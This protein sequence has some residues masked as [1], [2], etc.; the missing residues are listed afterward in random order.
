MRTITL[1]VIQLFA[2]FGCLQGQTITLTF[3]ATF[4]GL[5]Q[6][7]DSITVANI[8]QGGD[9]ILYGND[10]IL[11]LNHAIG[12]EDAFPN[13]SGRMILYPPSPNPVLQ[14]ATIRLYLPRDE[15]VTLSIHDLQGRE[16]ATFMQWLPA[17]DH[18]FTLI[19]G[20]ETCY[21]LS[22]ETPGQQQVQKLV[23]LAGTGNEP[24]IA[25][26]GTRGGL[27]SMKVS[28]AGFPW[29]P[30]D[31]MRFVG[32]FANGTDTLDGQPTQS[33]QYTFQY[34]SGLCPSTVTDFN[35]NIYNT[36]QIG[37]QCWMKE[38]LKVRNYKNGTSITLVTDNAA[39]KDITSSARC[40]YNNDSATYAATYG[41]LY[42]WYA[43]DN[44]SGLCPTGWHVPNELEWQTMEMFLGMTQ[45][46]ANSIGWRGT[47]EG[48]KMKEAG[49]THW[50]SPNTGATNSS[51]FTALPGGN[52]FN[53]DGYFYGI[54]GNGFW[55]SSTANSTASAWSR[56]LGGSYSNVARDDS[57]KKNGFYVRCLRNY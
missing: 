19:P 17:G 15:F 11:V 44:S 10:T 37:T 24:T 30:G 21:L 46:Q 13:H 31:Q 4:N 28:I 54:R 45:S 53:I 1:L 57:G 16:V 35:G 20:R 42:N 51:G 41:A 29:A 34:N 48:G 18:T 38:N 40:W 47:D 7:L 5:H 52:R 49:L 36:V 22:V 14:S 2:C 32:Y 27:N 8:T 23:S 50:N 56:G 9:T 6:P 33:A 25:Y 43:V 3:T 26:T 55:W 39:W 12:V